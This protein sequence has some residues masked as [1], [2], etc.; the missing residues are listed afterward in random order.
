MKALTLT[1][2]WASLVAL[3]CKRIETRSWYTMYTGVVCIH[4]AKG[5]PKD[6]RY[7]VS[8]SPFQ[9]ALCEKLGRTPVLA[10]DL[11]ISQIIAVATLTGCMTFVAETPDFIRDLSKRGELPP[12]EVDFGDFAAG[13]YGFMLDDVI[14]LDQPIQVRGALGLWNLPRNV[15][16]SVRRQLQ[17]QSA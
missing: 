1:Q 2:P 15:E 10:T 17:E 11:P 16:T 6:A 9:Q 8:E 12:N 4:A 5:F 3:G 13:R 14:P 7:V